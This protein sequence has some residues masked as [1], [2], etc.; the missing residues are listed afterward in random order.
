MALSR[1]HLAR[2]VFGGLVASAA[3]PLLAACSA[4]TQAVA[5]PG[6]TNA[7]NSGSAAPTS[8]NPLIKP[9]AGGAELT[10]LRASSELALGRNRFAVGLLDA[11]NQAVTSG[12]VHFEFFK[13]L[14]DGSGQKRAD[15]DAVFRTV[16]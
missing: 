11:R 13:L 16:G 2:L 5:T 10:I 9:R 6:A 14:K 12:A 1:R 7:G 4:G 15:A 3:V 8:A